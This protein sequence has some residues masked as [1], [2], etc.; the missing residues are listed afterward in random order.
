MVQTVKMAE[1]DGKVELVL[2][3]IPDLR[4]LLVTMEL[5]V[6]PARPVSRDRKEI[7]ANRPITRLK[8]K[9]VQMAFPGLWVNR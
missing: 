6:C 3:G 7:V 8:A 5:P 1:L 9:K 2:L 4:V